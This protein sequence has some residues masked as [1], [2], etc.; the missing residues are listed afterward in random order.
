MGATDDD[1]T[2]LVKLLMMGL[3]VAYQTTGKTIYLKEV[4]TILGFLDAHL[5]VTDKLH[6]WII[7]APPP[8][9]IHISIVWAV[10]SKH[11]ISY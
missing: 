4:D 10:M 5:L 7:A 11:F 9:T 8:K 3:M 1:Y 2:T 6:H